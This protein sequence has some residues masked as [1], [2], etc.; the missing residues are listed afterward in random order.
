MQ[1][2]KDMIENLMQMTERIYKLAPALAIPLSKDVTKFILIIAEVASE[3]QLLELVTP[4]D[5]TALAEVV[6]MREKTVGDI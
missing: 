5:W 4:L 2:M 3:L 1:D 6:K